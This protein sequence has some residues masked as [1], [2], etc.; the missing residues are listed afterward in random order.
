MAYDGPITYMDIPT[1]DKIEWSSDVEL[2]LADSQDNN[3]TPIP[4]LKALVF[5]FNGIELAREQWR[6]IL[7]VKDDVDIQKLRCVIL[8]RQ[9]SP[10]HNPDQIHHVLVVSAS[11]YPYV[12]YERMGVATVQWRHIIIEQGGVEAKII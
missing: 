6:L 12:G 11:S 9:A 1:K 7:D 8:G 3:A 2:S 10:Y 5:G 4:E